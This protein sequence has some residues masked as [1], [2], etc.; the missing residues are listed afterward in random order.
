MTK[1]D[2]VVDLL[3]WVMVNAVEDEVRLRYKEKDLKTNEYLF[4]NWSVQRD[5][6][7]AFPNC[8]AS[9]GGHSNEDKNL[10]WEI[11]LG[12]YA[13]FDREIPADISEYDFGPL[14]FEHT[15]RRDAEKMLSDVVYQEQHIVAA[16]KKQNTEDLER[17]QE[18][19][20]KKMTKMQEELARLQEMYRKEGLL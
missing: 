11:R 20:A 19:D 12:N 17:R 18:A 5:P 16:V 7:K 9:V 4:V 13:S 3:K 10:N 14:W 15:S 2:I 8:W 1:Y 6:K